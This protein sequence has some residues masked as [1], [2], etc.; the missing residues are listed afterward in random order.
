MSRQHKFMVNLNKIISILQKR[1]KIKFEKEEPFRVLIGVMLS[2]RTTDAVSWPATDR[3]FSRANTPKK[4]LKLSAKEIAKIIYPVG[5]YNTKAKRICE[6]CKIILKKYK[7]R[8][9]RTRKE[10]MEL[11]GVGGK[12][13]DIVLSFGF[14]EPVIAVDS[15]VKWVS[16]V[17]KI[18][19]EKNPEKVR[20][21]LH[22]LVP[23]K[24][25]LFVNNLFV[26]FGREICKTGRP[27]CWMCPVE[28]LCPYENKNLKTKSL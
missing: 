13:A 10:L 18:S 16:H 19:R 9:P 25:R 3:L 5:F 12:S 22:D 6:V 7:G 23:R 24:Y 15:H 17:L 2:H 1:Y 4:I 14:G 26:E 8:V 20:Q 11:P 28:K 27:K 21:A